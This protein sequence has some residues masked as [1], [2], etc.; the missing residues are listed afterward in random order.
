MNMLRIIHSNHDYKPW[1]GL[2]FGF[3]D[4]GS[5]ITWFDHRNP[6]EMGAFYLGKRKVSRFRVV[7]RM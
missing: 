7:L 4:L 5:K 2:E 6:M 3:Y 1:A